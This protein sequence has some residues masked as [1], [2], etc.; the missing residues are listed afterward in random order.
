MA[1]S[2]LHEILHLQA[3]AI[4]IDSTTIIRGENKSKNEAYTKEIRAQRERKRC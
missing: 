1:N 2:H 3:P 4:R